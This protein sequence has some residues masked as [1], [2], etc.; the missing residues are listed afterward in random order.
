MDPAVR[1]TAKELLLSPAFAAQ[2]LRHPEDAQ[3]VSRNR[4]CFF[5]LPYGKVQHELQRRR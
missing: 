1:P 3:R 5:F 4:C 2:G